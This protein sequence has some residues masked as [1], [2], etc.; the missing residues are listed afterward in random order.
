MDN[1]VEQTEQ[2]IPM[3]P[4]G[5]GYRGR[6]FGANYLDSECFGGQLYDMDDCD[7]DGL[8]YEPGEYLPCPKCRMEDWFERVTEDIHDGT[9]DDATSSLPLWKMACRFALLLSRDEA[10][11]LLTGRFRTVTY[12]E[13]NATGDDFIERQYEFDVEDF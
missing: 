2:E 4:A 11:R 9:H 8:I 7:D 6:E 12:V 1:Q 13:V 3:L 5:C 10:M